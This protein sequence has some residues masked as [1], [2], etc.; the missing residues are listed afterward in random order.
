MTASLLR[1]PIFNV[2]MMLLCLGTALAGCQS[3]GT[4]AA[5]SAGGGGQLPGDPFSGGGTAAVAPNGPYVDVNTG[6]ALSGYDP[7]AYFTHGRPVQG[8]ADITAQHNG[9]VYAFA[10]PRNREQFTEN[11]TAY[12]PAYDGYCAYAASLGQVAPGN[13]QNWSIVDGRLYLNVS[14][15]AHELWLEDVEG[16]IAR[17]DQL[18]PTMRRT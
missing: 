11:P 2:V 4:S 3:P 8:R 12:L 14:P 6:M 5:R 17:A 16:H 10:T 18:W 13:P 9:A 15:R 1:R 7:V